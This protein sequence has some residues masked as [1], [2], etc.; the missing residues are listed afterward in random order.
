MLFGKTPE[1]DGWQVRGAEGGGA[2]TRGIKKK[3]I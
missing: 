2:G 3:T 1:T